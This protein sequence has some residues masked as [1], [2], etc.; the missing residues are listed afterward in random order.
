[1]IEIRN[2]PNTLGDKTVIEVTHASGDVVRI[3]PGSSQSF[4]NDALVQV[5]TVPADPPF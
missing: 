4:E 3:L 1:M 2:V 5:R